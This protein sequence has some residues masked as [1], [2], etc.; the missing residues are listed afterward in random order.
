MWTKKIT[1]M[2]YQSFIR[3]EKILH[4]ISRQ[5]KTGSYGLNIAHS[6]GVSSSENKESTASDS[7]LRE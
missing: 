4:V 5:R 6:V 2:H 1:K 3:T 7:L